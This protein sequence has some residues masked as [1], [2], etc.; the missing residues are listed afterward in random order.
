MVPIVPQTAEAA[1]QRALTWPVPG[2]YKVSSCFGTEGGPCKNR[3]HHALDI[4]APRGTKV[5]AAYS[6]T[7]CYV[8]SGAGANYEM[9]KLVKIK[10]TINGSTMYTW[11]CHLSSVA[12]R[13]GQWVSAGQHIANVGNTGGN[14]GY[15][16]DFKLLK[17]DNRTRV[18]PSSWFGPIGGT[19]TSLY[20]Y[21]CCKASCNR[22]NAPKARPACAAPSISTTDVIGGKQVS[23]SSTAG[24]AIRYTTDGATNP[25]VN[26]GYVYSGSFFD[27]WPVMGVRAIASKSGYSSS[28]VVG[29]TIYNSQVAMPSISVSATSSGSVVRMSSTGGSTIY[30]TTDGTNPSPSHGAVYRGDVRLT[31]NAIVKAMAVRAGML[32]SGI[33][34]KVVVCEPPSAPIASIAERKVAVGDAVQV[35]WRADS[36]V[37]EYT[38][39]LYRDGSPVET[40][41]TQGTVASFVLDE[42]GE[43]SVSVRGSNAVGQGEECEPLKIE[44]MAPCKVRFVDVS[45]NEAGEEAAELLNEQ[46][47]RYGYGAT[48]P[49]SPKKRGYTFSG[50]SESFGKVTSDM[51]IAAEWDINTYVVQFYANDG[52]TRLSRQIVPFGSSASEP[53][54]EAPP[55]G[56][57]FSGWAVMDADDDSARDFAKVD[58]NMKLRAVYAWGDEELPVLSEIVDAKRT[59]SGNY[60]VRVRLTNYPTGSTT[61]L[62]RVALKTKEGK[63]VQTSRETVEIAPDG[64]CDQ[65]VTLKYSGDYIASVAEVEVVGLDGNYRTGGAYS[66]ATSTSVKSSDD[67]SYSA[68]SEW[69]TEKPAEAEGVEIEQAVQYTYRDRQTTQSTAGSLDGWVR[70]GTSSTTYGSWSGNKASTS[71]PGSNDVVR[72]VGQSTRYNYYHYCNKYGGGWNQDSIAYGSSSKY[73]SCSSTTLIPTIG[74][75]AD[76]GGKG[77]QARRGSGLKC[78]YNFTTWWLGSSTTTYT[79]QTRAKTVTHGYYRWGDWSSWSLEQTAPSSS[80]E[81]QSRTVYRMRTKT[82]NDLTGAEDPSGTLRTVSGRIDVA[83]DLAGKEATIMV[84]N[85]TNSDPNEDQLQY[86]G[87]TAIGP[88]NSYSFSFIPRSD[89]TPESGDYIV[90]LGI[91]GATGL[92]NVAVIKAPRAQHRVVFQ[93]ADK[94]GAVQVVS[95]QIVD[96]GGNADVPDSPARPGYR[97]AGWSASATRVATDLV[98]NALY[99]PETYTVAWVDWGNENVLMRTYSYG[100]ALVAPDEPEAEGLIFKGW[101]ALLSDSSVVKGNMVVNAVYEP[102]TYTVSFAD[103]SGRVI[104]SQQV[105]HGGS[106][107][108]PAE[109][110]KREGMVFLG[111]DTSEDSPW[112][113][114]RG[115]MT[116]SPLFAYENTVDSPYVAAEVETGLVGAEGAK[117]YLGCSTEGATIRF[118][119]DGS[120]PTAQSAVYDD[121]AGIAVLE[122]SNVKAAAFK[123]GMNDSCVTSIDVDATATNDLNNATVAVFHTFEHTGDAIEPLVDVSI[124]RTLLEKGVDYEV[125]YENNVE[126]GTGKVVVQGIGAYTGSSAAEFAIVESSDPDG[127]ASSDFVRRLYSSMLDVAEPSDFQVSYWSA[128]LDG[129][130]A[131]ADVVKGFLSSAAFVARDLSDE[132]VVRVL[133]SAMLGNDAP[134]EGQV[135]YWV[136]FLSRGNTREVLVDGFAASAAFK[137]ECGEYGLSVPTARTFSALALA[138]VEETLDAREDDPIDDD[139]AVNEVAGDPAQSDPVAEP[140]AS[141]SPALEEPGRP[142]EGGELI[143]GSAEPGG[144][145]LASEAPADEKGSDAEIDE[146]GDAPADEI[147]SEDYAEFILKSLLGEGDPTEADIDALAGELFRSTVAEAVSKIVATEAFADKQW[148]EEEAVKRLCALLL[149]DG[150]SPAE[151]EVLGYLQLVDPEKS[152]AQVIESMSR[153]ERY[154]S[155]CEKRGLTA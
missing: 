112:W 144:E 85:A 118:T 29:K 154:A 134:T 101:D 23:I 133:Y 125:V 49:A 91:K 62:L 50:W 111:W 55:T 69:S 22:L 107:R 16:L 12:V 88:D 1:D 102:K 103:A 30:Y 79:Y 41:A 81:V 119:T 129:G 2:Q 28:S 60:T 13:N 137:S 90:S 114:V 146:E 26:S 104:D 70:D 97:F 135:S 130:K 155:I 71:N 100:E 19:V 84:Y 73:H 35:S 148:S 141:E 126:V 116:V 32:N 7:V 48:K 9:G 66:K 96:E 45:A 75:F 53:V 42:V 11:Y 86:I 150:E 52:V 92:V 132:Q 64:T 117:V 4:A 89:P 106:A 93:S 77:S 82:P 33:S 74:G 65:E 140:D 128:Q 76:K 39:T 142:E 56:Y 108:I 149:A 3:S 152:Y 145:G 24:A 14:Y 34:E 37:G 63:L 127:L 115:D 80:R 8:Y 94:D 68:W 57:V 131:P 123:E 40:A 138:T 109:E 47:V 147:A 87:Q 99:V 43:Y 113:N 17:S 51:E 36:S 59:A 44:A 10:H 95:D 122:P 139:V 124:G 110:P 46:E 136:A 18:D 61:A 38:A 25:T 153:D 83:S 6:G 15:H 20:G 98:V 54:P 31:S 78:A 143:S 121:G 67:F 21:G 27:D 5:V 151:A 120:E 58:S 72:I 105:A